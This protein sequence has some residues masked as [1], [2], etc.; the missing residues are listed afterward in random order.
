MVIREVQEDL[1]PQVTDFLARQR[2]FG[3]RR[4]WDGLF[5]YSWK[6]K[7]YPY[8]YAAMDGNKVVAFIG[9]IYSDRVIEGKTVPYCNMSTWIVDSNYRSMLLGRMILERIFK[10]K[11]VFISSLTPS[12]SSREISEKMGFQLLERY[13]ITIPIFPRVAQALNGSREPLISFEGQEIQNHLS[14]E[15]RVIYEDHRGLKCTHFLVKE[16]ATGLYCYG[17]GTTA[18]LRR[19]RSF[20]AKW[21]NLCY[22]SNV[23]VFA[24]NFQRLKKYF[25]KYGRFLL[26]RYDSRLI[27]YAISSIELKSRR[28]R[29]FKSAAFSSCNL[30]NLYSELVTF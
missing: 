10:V 11:D 6:R 15:D 25:W 27:P 7:E 3:N 28:A 26:L 1:I 16:R 19:L 30:D 13:Q 2:E 9:T 24:R 17:I 14:R 23:D 22:L 29:Q 21:L 12:D 8:G 4:D 20:G 18:T 5:N